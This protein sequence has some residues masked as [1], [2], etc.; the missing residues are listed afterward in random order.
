MVPLSALNSL[1]GQP[2][3]ITQHCWMP[4]VSS[5]SSKVGQQI[6]H[7]PP[8]PHAP[9]CSVGPPLSGGQL[10]HCLPDVNGGGVTAVGGVLAPPHPPPPSHTNTTSGLM[11]NMMQYPTGVTSSVTNPSST[12]DANHPQGPLPPT[13]IE[14]ESSIIDDQPQNVM[15]LPSRPASAGAAAV[16]AASYLGLE[17]GYHNHETQQQHFPNF[18]RQMDPLRSQLEAPSASSIN[19]LP[20]GGSSSVFRELSSSR[21]GAQLRKQQSIS[22]AYEY[23]DDKMIGPTRNQT[24]LQS[25]PDMNGRYSENVFKTLGCVKGQVGAKL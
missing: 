21:R 17:S 14:P 10:Y 19:Y 9:L 23:C 13:P 12:T 2:Q 15:E 16:S 22:C 20:P 18:Y 25:I 8:P 11:L 7:P 24:Q 5:S 3:G 4:Q 6:I 1:D